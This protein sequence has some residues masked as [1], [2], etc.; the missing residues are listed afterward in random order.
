MPLLYTSHAP[1][2]GV[3]KI[4]ETWQ[5]LLAAFQC[6]EKYLDEVNAL[7]SDKRKQE[8][9]AVRLLLKKLIDANDTLRQTTV[10][11]RATSVSDGSATSRSHQTTVAEQT[12]TPGSKSETDPEP[13]I[14]H[15]KN[16]APF[17][18]DRHLHISIS[19]TIGYAAIILSA[20]SPAGVDIEYCSDRAWRLRDRFMN[21]QEQTLFTQF[22]AEQPTDADHPDATKQ[23]KIN[24]HLATLCWC[25]KEVAYKVLQQNEVDFTEHLRIRPFTPS[26]TG[27]FLLKETKTPQQHVFQ[28]DY[29]ITDDFVLAW[30]VKQET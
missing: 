4:T 5:E 3:W 23:T 24:H 17:I 15:H 30:H 2:L 19:H 25:A 21:K 11:R 8:W 13:T 7:K 29:R 14:D 6:P 9:L 1:I 12:C 28:I 20:E 10:V 27:F 16:G 22:V 18:P 26:K